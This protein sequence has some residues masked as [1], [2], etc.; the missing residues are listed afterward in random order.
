MH[1]VLFLRNKMKKKSQ[2]EVKNLFAEH[3]CE[4]LDEYLGSGFS[5]K[6]ICVC[7]ATKSISLDKFQKKIKKG[8]V[9]CH[10][11]NWTEE[12]DQILRD[13]YGNSTRS[14][15]L[16]KI[17]GSTYESI[18]HRAKVL[19]LI[20]NRN[21]VISEAR[22][23]QKPKYDYNINFFGNKTR[24]SIFWAGFLASCCRIDYKKNT[25]CI[26][27][28][29]EN[30]DILEAFQDAI[31]HTGVCS[32]TKSRVKLNIFRAKKWLLDLD[33][34]FNLNLKSPSERFSPYQLKDAEILVF[35]AGYLEGAGKIRYHAKEKKF[36]LIFC[37]SEEILNW[38]KI[39]F[40][41]LCPSLKK[42][43]LEI[44][45]Q[46]C[47]LFFYKLGY[48]KSKYLIKQIIS[49]NLSRSEEKWRSIKFILGV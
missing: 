4:L 33:N 6:Y 24:Q 9:V 29:L 7:G 1:M 13:L 16:S 30:Q 46:K 19:N 21:R 48:S 26:S 32:K 41:E 20:G 35:A 8:K 34:L 36:R 10:K 15:M 14:E 28:P 5:M 17:C 22:K 45:K 38:L 39:Y 3:G 31:C 47:N 49:L 11:I 43:Y 37:G 27:L 23:N 42:P 44:E 2:E 12:K 18:K 40:D 25:I